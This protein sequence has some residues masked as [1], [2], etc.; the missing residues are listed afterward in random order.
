MQTGYY[1]GGRLF[2][3]GEK[4]KQ[5]FFKPV[6]ME[7]LPLIS[8]LMPTRG[9]LMP[10]RFAIECFL[11]QTYP[12]RELVVISA[13][14]GSEVEQH[15]EAL[16]DPRIHFHRAAAA[17]TAGALRN[18][19]MAFARGEYLAIWDDDDLS[20]SDRLTGQMDA[21]AAL[22]ADAAMLDRELLWW[23]ERQRLAISA[24]RLWENSLLVRREAMPPFPDIPRGGDT[25]VA[26]VLRATSRLIAVD[27]PASY[28]YVFHGGNIWN[29]GHFEMLLGNATEQIEGEGYAAA[30][31][32]LAADM[33]IADYAEAVRDSLG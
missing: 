17:V 32:E 25:M 24:H 9:K 23:P 33:P 29:S 14:A 13:A 7:R 27:H 26:K 2:V 6:P 5:A 20:H 18:E 21:I 30:I 4:A 28:C 10:A 8:C 12:H 22:E 31:A 19:A 16:G 3:P 11:R 15:V 1:L